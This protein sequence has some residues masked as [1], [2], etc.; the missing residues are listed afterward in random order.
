MASVS[1]SADPPALTEAEKWR[2][3]AEK[4]IKKVCGVIVFL[5]LDL[6]GRCRTKT[7]SR[8]NSEQQTTT[9]NTTQRKE[10]SSNN[11]SN[12]RLIVCL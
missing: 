8:N 10:P 4:R 11:K 1:A 5:S 12:K 9:T 6:I 3:H 7:Y 2:E